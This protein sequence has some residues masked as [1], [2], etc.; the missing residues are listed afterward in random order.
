MILQRKMKGK[1]AKYKAQH[2]CTAVSLAEPDISSVGDMTPSRCP[3]IQA[4][5]RDKR[6]RLVNSGTL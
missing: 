4:I 1:W 6:T 3:N 5:S 2:M